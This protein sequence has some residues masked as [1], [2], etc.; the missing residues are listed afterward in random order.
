MIG[1][2]SRQATRGIVSRT[3]KSGSEKSSTRVASHLVVRVLRK[4]ISTPQ[5]SGSGKLTRFGALAGLVLSNAEVSTNP[6]GVIDQRWA[7]LSDLSRYGAPKALVRDTD[8][9]ATEQ[10][11]VAKI[12]ETTPPSQQLPDI[13]EAGR[14]CLCCGK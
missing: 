13:T 8:Y 9:A 5:K 6:V 4:A 10:F 7:T 11:P 2:L 12:E 14:R 3:Q 1:P